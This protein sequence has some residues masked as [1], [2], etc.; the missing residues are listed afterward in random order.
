MSK[1]SNGS[2]TENVSITIKTSV[3]FFL[4]Q[5]CDR[6]EFNR[7]QVIQ[8]AIKRLLAQEIAEDP[9]F[10]EKEYQKADEEV[11]L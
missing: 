8:A 6:K 2:P 4:D 11:K 3:L 7:S 5:Y 10:W 9:S 1:S